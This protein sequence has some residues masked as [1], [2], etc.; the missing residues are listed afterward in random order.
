MNEIADMWQ[1]FALTGYPKHYLKY[2]AR[3]EETPHQRKKE[4]LCETNQ[5]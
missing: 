2:K 3:K 4:N 1:L 5:S